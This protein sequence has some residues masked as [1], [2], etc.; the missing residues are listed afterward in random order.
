MTYDEEIKQ[1]KE[2]HYKNREKIIDKHKKYVLPVGLDGS[3]DREE[4]NEE[5]KRFWAEVKKLKEKYNIEK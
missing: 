4:L 5:S 3:P 2:I 1:L